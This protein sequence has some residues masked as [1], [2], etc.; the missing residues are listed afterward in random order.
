MKLLNNVTPINRQHPLNRGLL[1]W[2]LTLPQKHGGGRW[3]ELT[4]KSNATITGATATNARLRPGGWGCYEYDGTDDG[5]QTATIDLSGI[6]TMTLSCALYWN[7]FAD[8]NDMLFES[9]ADSSAAARQGAISILPN[10]AT[11]SSFGVRVNSSGTQFNG[12]RFTRPSAA[13]WHWY[14]FCFNRA[15]GA[16]QVVAVYVDGVSQTLTTVTTEATSTGGFGNWAWNF[17]CRNNA[18]LYGAGKLDDVSIRNRIITAGEA[19]ALYNE[20]RAGYPN[21][22]RWLPGMPNWYAEEA[23]AI[24]LFPQQRRRLNQM[25]TYIGDQV[26]DNTALATAGGAALTVPA[27]TNYMTLEAT[28][29]TMNYELDGVTN[30]PTTGTTGE[31]SRL[32][33]T[34]T[35]PVDCGFTTFRIIRQADVAGQTVKVHYYGGAR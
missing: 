28:G 14:S 8:D 15:A 16:Q 18:S 30:V 2:W 3:R 32:Y 27:G 7:A 23:A 12:I 20:S 4:G 35:V 6:S 22:I 24:T 26:L 33:S 9:S 5:A 19:K 29:G 21:A 17:M 11:S 31:G 13:T 1:R 25:A 10:F 34:Q